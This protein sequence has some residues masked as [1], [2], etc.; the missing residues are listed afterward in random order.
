MVCCLVHQHLEDVLGHL[1]AEWHMQEPTS[2]MMC[3][4]SGQI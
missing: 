4:K 2:A 3:V 1:Q